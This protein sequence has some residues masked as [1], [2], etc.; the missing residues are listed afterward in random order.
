MVDFLYSIKRNINFRNI[1]GFFR[2]NMKIYSINVKIGISQI[3]LRICE[4]PKVKKPENVAIN[5]TLL[6]INTFQNVIAPG[7][8]YK[9]C[10]ILMLSEI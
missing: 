10:Q 5:L 3:F 1:S 2:D 7:T 6:K 4:N 9:K 8:K